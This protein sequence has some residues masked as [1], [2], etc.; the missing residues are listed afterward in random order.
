MLLANDFLTDYEPG[1]TADLAQA[2]ASS[3]KSQLSVME[4]DGPAIS[5]YGVVL[6][7]SSGKGIAG[8][9]EKPEV[10]DAPSN[11]VSIGRYVLTPD[12][13][14]TLR[15]LSVGSGGETQLADSNNIHAQRGTVDTEQLNR[16]RFDC[17]SVDEYVAA[18][19]HEYGKRSGRPV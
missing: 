13:F 16:Q 19:T 17:G 18:V 9:I 10:N 2:F 1:V 3:G 8:L 12:I 4:V 6:P 15:G 11:L 7:N 5:K 14:K